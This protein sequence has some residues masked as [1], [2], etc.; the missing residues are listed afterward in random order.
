M[1]DFESLHGCS[2]LKPDNLLIDQHGHLKLTDFGLSRIGLLGRQTG[3]A[4]STLGRPPAK[5]S[6][7]SRPPSI[8]MGG[9]HP[10][11]PSDVNLNGSYF[12]Q[13]LARAAPL[14]RTGSSPFLFSAEDATG[15]SNAEARPLM[16]PV[17]K[18]NESPMASFATE[19][20]NDLRSY[21]G[22]TPPT[23]RKFVG[24]PDYLA[25]ETILGLK[26]DDAAV[27]WVS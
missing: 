23:D 24:T 10:S 21:A 9:I 22:N 4:Q 2:D 14:Q 1:F 18:T 3:D 26:G 8:D 15:S 16:R 12:N 11:P 6:P 19:L 7:H 13:A 20:T 27:D 17:P 25:P 5:L